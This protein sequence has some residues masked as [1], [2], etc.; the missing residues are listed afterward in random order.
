MFTG[1][2]RPVEVLFYW[3]EVVFGNFHWPGAKGPLLASSPVFIV[4]Y[5]YIYDCIYIYIY[6]KL[7]DTG[8]KILQFKISFDSFDKVVFYLFPEHYRS[9]YLPKTYYDYE[10]NKMNIA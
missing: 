3:P 6:A 2:V 8:M 4:I 7:P 10:I 9:R 1:P 5:V